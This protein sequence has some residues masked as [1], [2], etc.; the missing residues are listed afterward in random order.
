ME[1]H[2]NRVECQERE[3][4]ALFIN[5][6]K[7]N[8]VK[9]IRVPSGPSGCFEFSRKGRRERT[10]YNKQQLEVLEAHFQKTVLF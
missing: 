10:S 1:I 5:K 9:Q 6:D 2:L 4:G 3:F 8:N 7:V